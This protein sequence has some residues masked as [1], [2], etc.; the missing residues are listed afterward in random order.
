MRF[1]NPA[2]VLLALALPIAASAQGVPISQLPTLSGTPAPTAIVPIVQPN[3][4]AQLTT[5][6]TTVSAI[7]GSA[8][9]ALTLPAIFPAGIGFTA[10]SV[11]VTII[12]TT[13]G[14]LQGTSNTAPALALANS[15]SATTSASL[16]GYA[17]ST[18]FLGG[19]CIGGGMVNGSVPI[20]ATSAS[21]AASGGGF[22]LH[23]WAYIAG[24]STAENMTC[25]PAVTSSG[26]VSV[27]CVGG[28]TGPFWTTT[29]NFTGTAHNV[30]SA[31]SG[32]PCETT[33]TC[34][35]S[36]ATTCS[37]TASVPAGSN[38]TWSPNASDTTTGQATWRETSLVSTTLTLAV[39]LTSQTATGAVN[40]GCD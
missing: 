20:P 35:L 37:A 39:T 7:W 25:Q 18:L 13:I 26:A 5:Y 36:T 14:A 10:N 4:G 21:P 1:S 40:I 27:A 34:S 38:C 19:P 29:G 12:Q 8:L 6:Q 33:A 17:N 30:C 16:C 23:N 22:T 28:V 11:N 2:I 31:T 32:W 3:S 15:T 24:T 9:A